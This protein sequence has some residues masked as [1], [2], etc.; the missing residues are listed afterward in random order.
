M[1]TVAQVIFGELGPKWIRDLLTVLDQMDDRSRKKM[2]FE[3]EHGD[4]KKAA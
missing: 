4:W 2:I 1:I 3:R